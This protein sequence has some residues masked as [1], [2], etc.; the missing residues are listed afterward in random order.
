MITKLKLKEANLIQEILELNS[1][2][3]KFR[4]ENE[5]L[6]EKIENLESK[7]ISHSLF[8]YPSLEDFLQMIQRSPPL[9]KYSSCEL[10]ENDKKEQFILNNDKELYDLL[11]GEKKTVLIRHNHYRFRLD[12]KTVLI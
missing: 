6:K 2:L 8:N 4:E 1:D 9:V 11:F 10:L 7:Q 3:R 12:E 5:K